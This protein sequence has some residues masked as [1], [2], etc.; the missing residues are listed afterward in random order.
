MNKFLKVFS[1]VVLFTM[2]FAA[3]APKSETAV[4]EEAPV[5]AEESAAKPLEGQEITFLTIQPH[6]VAS[7]NL[8]QWFEEETGCKVTVDV[9]PY[10]NV[11]E[12]AVLDVTSGVGYY[13]V[14]DFWYPGLG[15]L[16]EN[17]V[18]RNLDDWYAENEEVLELDDLIVTFK[19]VFT[20]I[21]GSKYAF[22]FDGDMHLLYYNTE[23]FDMYGQTF[24]A[25]WDEYLNTC[26]AITE[27]GAADGV[28]GCAIM[29]AKSPLILIG[30]FLNRFG[31]YGGA[32]FDA[33]G[34]PTIN[35]PEAV[36]ALTGMVEQAQ[37]ALPTA[38]AVAFDEALGGWFTG[39]AAMVE[40]WTDLPGMTDDPESSSIVGKWGVGHLPIG[41]GDNAKVV[42]SVN[43]GFAVGVS[44]VAPH[45][46]AAMEFLN[47]I[48][49][50][51]IAARYNT[52][53][54]GIDPVRYSTLEDPAYIEFAGQE[55]V[56]A[57]K[58]AHANAI[59]WSTSAQWF[60]LQEPLTDNLSLALIG[61]K[62]PQQALD[63]TQAAWLQILGK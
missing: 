37:Y 3:C 13:D 61:D 57:I 31:A 10:D 59:T 25:T 12:K 52:V 50:P 11:V 39:K 20:T 45:P 15:T 35:S 53:V 9:V 43:A 40:F 27:A 56:D 49:R 18:L 16:V 1:I 41:S 60:E 30:S 7:Q 23:I 36:A 54:G 14:V 63:D 32:F 48:A 29:G 55:I 4:V 62:T 28:Y 21:D 5:V 24:P 6:T 42:A 33:D 58:A 51:D 38:S 2:I 34:N 8:A 47:F 46:D 19:D 17:G 44:A 26:K 22:P